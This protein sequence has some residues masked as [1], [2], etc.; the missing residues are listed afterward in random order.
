MIRYLYSSLSSATI[1]NSYYNHCH[2]ILRLFDIL[3]NFSSVTSE[4]K[5]SYNKNGIYTLP[6]EL[7]DNLRLRILENKEISGKS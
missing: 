6:Q 1:S 2:T 5:C 7:P 4:T 3:P